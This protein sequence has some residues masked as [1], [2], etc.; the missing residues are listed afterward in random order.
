VIVAGLLACDRSP[1]DRPLDRPTGDTGCVPVTEVPGDGVDEGCNGWTDE[2]G[3][4]EDAA[5]V[6]QLVVTGDARLQ[7]GVGRSVAVHQDELGT[8]LAVGGFGVAWLDR[9]PVDGMAEQQIDTQRGGFGFAVAV[10]DWAEPLAV[11]EEDSRVVLLYTN[12]PRNDVGTLIPF[13]AQGMESAGLAPGAADTLLLGSGGALA[14]YEEGS[15]EPVFEVVNSPS[16]DFAAR[17]GEVETSP[18][19]ASLI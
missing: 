6:A 2:L 17:V 19:T 3:L 5:A 14:G 16:D 7:S 18:A 11:A 15:T 4:G 10:T 13:G 9:G 8:W 12:D 1:G